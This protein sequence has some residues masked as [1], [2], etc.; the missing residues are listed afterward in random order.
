MIAAEIIAAAWLRSRKNDA[1]IT[2]DS[3]LELLPVLQRKLRKRIAQSVRV[4]RT[5]YSD[6][7]AVPAFNSAWPR[8]VAAVSVF[9][10]ERASGKQV[11]VVDVDES[12]A[13]P[14]R[15]SVYELGG[16]FHPAGVPAGPDPAETLTFFFVRRAIVP[17]TLLDSIDPAFPD[18]H[19]D[20][21][22]L[23][24][25]A[26]LALKDGRSEELAIIGAELQEAEA[27]YVQSLEHSTLNVQRR[28]N[29][30]QQFTSQRLE[31][32]K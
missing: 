32:T 23:D 11:A 25:A 20:V 7:L 30:A 22:I 6:V 19:V 5:F 18:D 12:D 13:D 17:T 8:P 14:A 10:I 4:N 31:A 29:Q 24:V 1:E 9:R 26:H 16:A 27:M 3:E 2:A 28:R 21:L 15:P